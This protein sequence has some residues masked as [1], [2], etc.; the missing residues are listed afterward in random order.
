M[1]VIW[2]HRV[3]CFEMMLEP[4]PDASRRRSWLAVLIGGVFLSWFCSDSVRVKGGSYPTL[5]KKKINFF[6]KFSPL[7]WFM[8]LENKLN[9]FL[10]GSRSTGRPREGPIW[11][12]LRPLLVRCTKISEVNF[13]SRMSLNLGYCFKSESLIQAWWN[14][15]NQSDI[16]QVSASCAWIHDASGTEIPI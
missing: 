6:F 9:H 13:F 10:F 7:S 3:N 4:F 14:W 16:L 1:L 5:T 2:V 11:C 8:I 15:I 12:S